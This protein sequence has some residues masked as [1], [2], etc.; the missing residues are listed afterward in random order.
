MRILRDVSAL[1]SRGRSRLAAAV[2]CCSGVLAASAPVLAD[3]LSGM[4]KRLSELRGE[5]ETLSDQLSAQKNDMQEQLRSYARQKSELELEIQREETRTQKLRQ[6][7]A[8]KRSETEAQQDQNEAVA[9]A[10]TKHLEAVRSYVR[11]SLP[12][13]TK[14]RLAELDKLEEQVKGGLLAPGRALNRLWGF[15]EDEMRMTRESGLFSQ[16][17]LVHGKEQLAEVARIGMVAMYYKTSDDEFGSTERKNGQWTFRSIT[18][19]AGRK[20][21]RT[22]FETFKKQIRVGYFELPNALSPSAQ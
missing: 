7:V 10:F 5:V 12:F 13:R 2:L 3:E 20:E 4:A 19:E 1:R 18:D 15:V 9:P 17:V 8:H 22:L 16:P 11:G 14:E 21:V 6:A